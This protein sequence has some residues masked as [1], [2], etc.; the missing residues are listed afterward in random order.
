MENRLAH[1]HVSSP[2]VEHVIKDLDA[3]MGHA[4]LVYVREA[5]SEAD[6]HFV[7]Y[8]SY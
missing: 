8:L 4:N 7:F 6:V 5:H 1:H 2:A 3:Q